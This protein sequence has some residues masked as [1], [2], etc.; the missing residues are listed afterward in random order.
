MVWYTLYTLYMSN[1][2]TEKCYLVLPEHFSV[3]E[4]MPFICLF[5]HSIQENCFD[6]PK[7]KCFYCL[8]V[9]TI[10]HCEIK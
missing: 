2:L 3:P 5:F 4:K 7:I 8:A 10:K 6:L 1:P 9:F